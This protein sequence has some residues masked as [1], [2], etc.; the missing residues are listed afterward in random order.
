M[1]EKVDDAALDIF[2]REARTYSKWQNKPIPDQ[3]LRDLYERFYQ[4]LPKL[5][6]QNPGMAKLFEANR[7]L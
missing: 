6:A 3:T 7:S 2:F 1:G 4:Q 5:F